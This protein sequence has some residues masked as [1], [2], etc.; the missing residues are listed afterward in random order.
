MA[1]ITGNVD[2]LK[3]LSKTPGVDVHAR[4]AIVS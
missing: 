1:V 3:Y 4:M 2:I